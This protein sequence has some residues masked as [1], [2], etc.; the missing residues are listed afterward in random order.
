MNLMCRTTNKT[1]ATVFA[2]GVST[3]S[4]KPSQKDDLLKVVITRSINPQKKTEVNTSSEERDMSE[5]DIIK[6]E[7]LKMRT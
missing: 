7:N 5:R 2:N 6:N 1:T 4:N 3:S